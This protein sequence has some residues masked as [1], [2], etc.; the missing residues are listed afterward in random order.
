M[1]A[2][3]YSTSEINIITMNA[4]NDAVV[5]HVAKRIATDSINGT[6]AEKK[7]AAED[8]HQHIMGMSADEK[9]AF[10]DAILAY[11]WNLTAAV[12]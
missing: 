5:N 8:Y 9:A 11:T 6:D 4:F 12:R 7:T 1:S 2:N 3:K 10:D